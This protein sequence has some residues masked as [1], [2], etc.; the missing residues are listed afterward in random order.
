MNRVSFVSSADNWADVRVDHSRSPQI[1]DL[2]QYRWRAILR[3]SGRFL[4]SRFL[5]IERRSVSCEAIV[6][7]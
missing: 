5:E 3:R 7:I 1:H 2:E 4:A 6:L